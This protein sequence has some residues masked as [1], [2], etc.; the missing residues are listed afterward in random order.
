MLCHKEE[1]NRA[2]EDYVVTVFILLMTEIKGGTLQHIFL[3][4]R[5]HRCPLVPPIGLV[6]PVH[7][8]SVLVLVIHFINS[9]PNITRYN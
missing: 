2:S 3:D 7:L 4:D 5:D 9:L 1:T 6:L 8:S